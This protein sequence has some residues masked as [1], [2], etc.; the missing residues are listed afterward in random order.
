MRDR[1]GECRYHNCTHVHEPGCAVVEAL[2]KGEIAPSRYHNYLSMLAG[3][4]NRR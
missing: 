1:L 2:E 3:D 4:D